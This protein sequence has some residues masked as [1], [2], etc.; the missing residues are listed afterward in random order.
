MPDVPTIRDMALKLEAWAASLPAED[1]AE[2]EAW[3]RLGTDGSPPAGTMWWFEPSY[4]SNRPSRRD[5]N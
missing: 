3:M 4:D 2:V 5:G 1:R